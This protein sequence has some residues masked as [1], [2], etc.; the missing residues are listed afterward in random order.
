MA[1]SIEHLGNAGR[2]NAVA[3]R[4]LSLRRT[5]TSSTMFA[6]AALPKTLLTPRLHTGNAL[7]KSRRAKLPWRGVRKAN[8][9]LKLRMAA[10]N[11]DNLGRIAVVS[12]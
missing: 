12:A 10:L 6:G 2:P 3:S 1:S 5:S 8:A 11:L 7:L 9:W 4:P